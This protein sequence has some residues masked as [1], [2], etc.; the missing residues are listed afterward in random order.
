MADNGATVRERIADQLRGNQ[1]TP[2]DLADQFQ[3]S[4]STAINHVQHIARSVDQ[5]NERIEVAPPACKSCGFDSFDDPANLPSRCPACKAESI[6]EPV[7][8]LSSRSQ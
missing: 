6:S 3:I 2:S 4:P 7:F 5:T 1:A 8:R